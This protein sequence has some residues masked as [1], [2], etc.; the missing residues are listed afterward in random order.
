MI[1]ILKIDNNN[2]NNDNNN[3]NR[4]HNY[5][6]IYLT[7][8]FNALVSPPNKKWIFQVMHQVFK[9]ALSLIQVH[10]ATVYDKLFILI[11]LVWTCSLQNF[12]KNNRYYSPIIWNMISQLV[13]IFY[14]ALK[15]TLLFKENCTSQEFQPKLL[16]DTFSNKARNKS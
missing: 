15:W 8:A 7:I 5:Y 4:F 12:K 14:E 6:E 1:I 9:V 13:N 2:N 11:C 3:N 16:K 10:W